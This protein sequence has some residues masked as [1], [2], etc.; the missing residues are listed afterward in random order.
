MDKIELSACPFCGSSRAEI[1]GATAF[2]GVCLDCEASTGLCNSREEAALK[3]NRRADNANAD[4]PLCAD[5][6]PVCYTP[7][8]CRFE[9]REVETE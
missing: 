7:G 9:E 6:C 2:Y 4:C 5:F 3:W 8:V 1:H